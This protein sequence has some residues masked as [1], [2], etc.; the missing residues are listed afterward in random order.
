MYG[1][2]RSM[3]IKVVYDDM[4]IAIKC[5]TLNVKKWHRTKLHTFHIPGN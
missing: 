3:A 4:K 1:T 5:E 2:K